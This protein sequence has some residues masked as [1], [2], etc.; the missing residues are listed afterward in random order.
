M[1]I[2]LSDQRVTFNKQAFPKNGW[3][4]LMAGIPG[5]GKSSA[6]KNYLL[7]DATVFDSDKIKMLVLNKVNSDMKKGIQSEMTKSI[8]DHFNGRIPNIANEEDASEIH[9]FLITEKR[10]FSKSIAQFLKNK[11]LKENFIIDATG[12]KA[13]AITNS[14]KTF[15]NLGYKICVVLV[16]TNLKIA[17]DRALSRQNSKNGRAVPEA[18]IDEVYNSLIKN[19]PEVLNNLDTNVVD[20]FWV[21]LN[22]E[23]F[24]LL[25]K[26]GNC[27]K[28][29]KENDKFVLDD[30]LLKK[31]QAS[32]SGV[33]MSDSIFNFFDNVIVA[34][35]L[36]DETKSK[37]KVISDKKEITDLIRTDYSDAWAL[38][39]NENYIYR[40]TER[41]YLNKEDFAVE[42]TP[43]IRISKDGIPNLYTI[44]LSEIL[45][46]WKKFPKRNRSHICSLDGHTASSYGDYLY[47]VLPKNGTKIGVCPYGDIW[48]SFDS[49]YYQSAK[50]LVLMIRKIFMIV[51]EQSDYV[52]DNALKDASS[53]IHL[54][55][56]FDKKFDEFNEEEQRQRFIDMFVDIYD[57]TLMLDY[58]NFVENDNNNK[59]DFMKFLERKIFNTKGFSVKSLYNID[60]LMGDDREVW[61]EGPALYIPVNSHHQINWMIDNV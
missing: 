37:F 34:D 59:S 40:G 13:K 58:I 32:K 12:N 51:L 43:G 39:D 54:F 31:I 49:T 5:S 3:A 27:I 26:Q 28:L 8:V 53:T 47:Y 2:L 36:S 15:K 46:S 4:I 11:R 50:D 10:L 60:S 48:D 21:I 17:K 1:R 16:A 44:L 61:F 20:E 38:F 35:S 55:E 18:Y 29:K 41:K 14:S 33:M 57:H 42:V 7:I 6:I 23:E 25:T 45:D 24:D 52:I 22:N 30:E 9:Q 56:A 19:F